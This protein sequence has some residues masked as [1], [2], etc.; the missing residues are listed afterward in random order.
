M[1]K[2]KVG[3]ET[4]NQPNFYFGLWIS[5]EE[6]KQRIAFPFDAQAE[7][8]TGE[9]TLHCDSYLSAEKSAVRLL[10]PSGP[11]PNDPKLPANWPWNEQH[12]TY[13]CF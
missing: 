3:Q 2:N 6:M 4:V 12:H 13:T 8:H 1:E 11:N 5:I 9:S 7:R 10:S